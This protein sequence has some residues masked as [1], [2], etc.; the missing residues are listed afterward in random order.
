MDMVERFDGNGEMGT[1]F[2]D[3]VI[4]EVRRTTTCALS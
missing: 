2:L 3:F 4:C 1:D